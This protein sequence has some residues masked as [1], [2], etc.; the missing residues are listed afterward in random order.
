MSA[1][2][3]R[4]EKVENGTGLRVSAVPLGCIP[5]AENALGSSPVVMATVVVARV[6]NNTRYQHCQQ[7]TQRYARLDSLKKQGREN[8][9]VAKRKRRG[10]NTEKE[11][12]HTHAIAH[13]RPNAQHPWRLATGW[14]AGRRWRGRENEGMNV[15]RLLY[16]RLQRYCFS[17]K[18]GPD[19]TKKKGDETR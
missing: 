7:D 13:P 11:R 1:I 19:D 6:D 17:G 9:T 16:W 2:T 14:R 4:N 8:K 15:L 3:K 5:A 10:T 18:R 12:T